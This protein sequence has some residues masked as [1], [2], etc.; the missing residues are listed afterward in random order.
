MPI[1]DP[2]SVQHVLQMSSS[3]EKVVVEA[4][5]QQRVDQSL[6]EERTALDDIEQNEIQDPEDT[7]ESNP[8]DP[9]GKN[10]NRQVR[11]KK[12]QAGAE[13]EV[14]A[15]EVSVPIVEGNPSSH[16]DLRV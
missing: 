6:K 8:S 9:D 5:A 12:K 10:S 15:P 3:V 16:L 13:K 14:E 4:Q 1:I 11:I 7:K 2:A